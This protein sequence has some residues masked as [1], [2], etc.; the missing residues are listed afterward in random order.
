MNN[1]MK[2]LKLK[3]KTLCEANGCTVE[4][5]AVKGSVLR[6][7]LAT[8]SQIKIMHGQKQVIRDMIDAD[9]AGYKT[10]FDSYEDRW[11]KREGYKNTQGVEAEVTFSTLNWG[12]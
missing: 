2:E 9:G 6:V 10:A 4:H 7:H 8:E 12:I 1:Y 5:L 3:I 11:S